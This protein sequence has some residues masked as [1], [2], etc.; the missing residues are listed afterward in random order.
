MQ[1]PAAFQRKALKRNLWSKQI[2]IVKAI[3]TMRSVAIKGCHASGKTFVL[4]GC[5]PYELLSSKEVIVLVIAPTLRQVKNFWGEVRQAVDQMPFDL[6]EPTTTRWELSP[7]CFAQGFS[8]AKGV[9]AQ[10]FHGRRVVIIVD[11]AM[12]VAQDLWDAIDGIRMG[13]DV[14]LV[15]LCNPTVAGGPVYES[16]TKNRAVPGHQCITISA[17]DTPNLAGLTVESLLEL[18]EE[19]LDLAVAPGLTRRRAVKEMYFKWGPT[20]PRFISRVLGEFPS[21][22]SDAVFQLAWIEK[23]SL[24]YEPAD[25]AKLLVPGVF[26]QVGVDVAGPGDDETAATARIGQFVISRGAWMKADAFEEVT[27]FLGSIN[28]RFPGVPVIVLGDVVGIGWHFMTQIARRGYTTY[29]FVAGAAPLNPVMFTNAKAEQY[30]CLREWMREGLI[31][32]IEDEDTI[33]QLSDV[34]YR[35]TPMG[36][37]EIESKDEARGRGSKSPDRAESVI[38]AFARIVQASQT[39]LIGDPNYQISAV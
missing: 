13:G 35:E 21:Q 18:S 7:T 32:G 33:A 1:G 6:P 20:N 39:V 36:R 22:A 2:E 28:R 8:A 9:N 38:M 16:F 5:V 14:T 26:V 34:R 23:A 27:A 37:I 3:H 30:W 10:S 11:E 17:F 31:H 24:P 29:G 15:T 19:E 25:L 12:G 4:S